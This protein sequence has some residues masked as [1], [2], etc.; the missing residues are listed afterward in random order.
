VAEFYTAESLARMSSAKRVEGT[1]VAGFSSA[2]P[3]IVRMVIGPKEI[4]KFEVSTTTLDVP[5]VY[6]SCRAEEIDALEY[7]PADGSRVRSAAVWG[8]RCVNPIDTI[9]LFWVYAI[10]L[11]GLTFG[12]V[13]VLKYRGWVDW[14]WVCACLSGRDILE[15]VARETLVTIGGHTEAAAPAVRIDRSG[16]GEL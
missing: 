12:V 11:V 3:F 1:R 5:V 9:A 4:K 6:A 8:E 16:S 2:D 10:V 15:R 13:A 14:R 7:V